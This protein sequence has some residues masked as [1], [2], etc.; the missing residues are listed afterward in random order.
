M[1]CSAGIAETLACGGLL[2][3]VSATK[4]AVP[5][6]VDLDGTLIYSDTLLEDRKSVV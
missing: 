2:M 5:L 1:D 4:L 3:A 6:C